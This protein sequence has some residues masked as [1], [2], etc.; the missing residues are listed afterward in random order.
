[1]IVALHYLLHYHIFSTLD[2][3]ICVAEQRLGQVGI[4]DFKKHPFFAGIDWDSI[5]ETKPPYIPEFTSDTDT[6][7][8]DPYD[9]EE[10]GRSRHVSTHPPCLFICTYKYCPFSSLTRTLHLPQT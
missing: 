3:L 1:M 7:N 4:D 5:R 10:D 8:F 6:R 9:P 2:R